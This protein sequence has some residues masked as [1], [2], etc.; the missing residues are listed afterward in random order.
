MMEDEK[1]RIEEEKEKRLRKSRWFRYTNEEMGKEKF[2]RK[3]N[4]CFDFVNLSKCD[5]LLLK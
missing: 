3:Y 1:R 5:F 2:E 4:F